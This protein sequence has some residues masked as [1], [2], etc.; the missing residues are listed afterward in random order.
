LDPGLSLEPLNPRSHESY[1]G[2]FGARIQRAELELLEI[3]EEV[4]KKRFSWIFLILLAL[5]LL[6]LGMFVSGAGAGE[7]VQTHGTLTYLDLAP[8]LNALTWDIADWQWKHGYDTGFVME[9]LLMGDLQK[10]PRGSKK[11]DFEN[12]A[13][14]PPDIMTGELLQS[15]EVKKKPKM[16]II[17]HLRKGVMWQEKPFMKSRELVAD[18]VVYSINRIKN[19]PKAIPLYMDF[20]GKMETP[21]KYT[22]VVNMTE[23]CADWHYRMGWGYY[24]AIQAPEQ[25]KA[26]GGPKQWQNLTGT[27]PYMLT[28]YKEGHDQ[29][30]SRNPNYWGYE[31]IDGKKYH[32]PLNDK[33]I[34]MIMRD[35]SSQLAA[36]R[37][38]KLDLVMAIDW[39]QVEN[40]KKSCPQLKWSNHLS[41]G[42][43]TMAMRMDRK[44]FNDVRVRRAMNLAVNQQEIINSFFGGHAL[45]HTYP[46]PPSF[47]DVYTPLD[48]LPP[49]VRELYT[50]N[51]EKAKKLL[52]EAGYPNGFTFK[53][54]VY[55]ESQTVLDEVAMVSA[56]LAKVGVKMDLETMNYPS[57]LS[58]MLRKT[59]ADGYFFANDHGGPYSGIRKNFLTGQT[60]NP[61][62]MSDPYVDKTWDE[63]VQNP[64]Y[65]DKTASEAIKKLSIYI[66]E[67]VPCLILPTPYVYTAWWPWVKNYYGELRVGAHRAAPI[68]ARIWIDQDLKKKMGY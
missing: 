26:P 67:Q 28:E 23:W 68:M 52:A 30:Y 60:W 65:N 6:S 31:T 45:L 11:I 13:W 55:S 50:Y 21:D 54:Q 34:M 46:F 53:A 39:R 7:T 24:D 8:G 2:I 64:N 29:T 27:G 58:K 22:V 14:V 12:N 25:E 38:G 17:L 51:P 47:K 1:F 43:F 62:M 18:D 56:Y 61:H 41:T 9:H 57:Y 44:P 66:M 36:L 49:D 37:T 16:Q 33:V 20:V 4:M 32:L 40:L 10:G 63:I 15:W 42:N 19:S 59:H 35:E 3:K 5:S 48:K